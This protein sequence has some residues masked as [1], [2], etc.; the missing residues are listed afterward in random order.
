MRI[1]TEQLKESSR[2][3]EFEVS[4]DRFP[5]LKEMVLRRECDF[6]SPIQTR[7]EAARIGEMVPIEG[8]VRTAVRLTCGRCLGQFTRSLEFEFALTYTHELP[9]FTG[10]DPPPDQEMDAADVGLIAFR[11]E[12]ID[13]TEGIQE[14]VILALPLRALCSETC[15]GLCA[16]CGTDLNRGD[17]R[18][19]RPAEDSPFAALARIKP[20]GGDRRS[21]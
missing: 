1:H 19:P 20:G 8:T 9:G 11:G 18:C 21:K 7:L 6:A 4:A 5:S 13:L 3:F 15:K 10:A 12:E 14:Q 2:T 16:S 17:C